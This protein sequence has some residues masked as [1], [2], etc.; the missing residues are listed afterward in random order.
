VASYNGIR[1]GR[2]LTETK[3]FWNIHRTWAYF[4]PAFV[5]LLFAAVR[6]SAGS[7]TLIVA[8]LSGLLSTVSLYV[9]GWMG[10]F[11]INYIWSGPAGLYREQQSTIETQLG[12]IEQLERA[13]PKR[14]PA[15]QHHFEILKRAIEKRGEDARKVLRHLRSQRTVAFRVSPARG[16]VA[17][18]LIPADMNRDQAYGMMAS[19]AIDLVLTCARGPGQED[20]EEIF[21]IAQGVMPV[22]D[23]LIYPAIS[24]AQHHFEILHR[25]IDK[26]GEDARKVLRHLRSNGRVAFTVNATQGQL[27]ARTLMPT[28]MNSKQAYGTMTSLEVA[29]VLTCV[30]GP[31]QEGREEV[32]EVFEIAPGFISVVDELI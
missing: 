12:T 6:F 25:T 28:D 26:C 24:S 15:D 13:K 14:S 32:L 29:G 7:S 27:S 11:L 1:F 19:L 31:G 18:T 20:H 9:V 17:I 22:V 16:V 30:R 5:G 8:A 10:S 4:V 23:D 21:E 3:Q 2:A